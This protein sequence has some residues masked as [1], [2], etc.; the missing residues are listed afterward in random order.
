MT[1]KS[2]MWIWSA[3]VLRGHKNSESIADIQQLRL[4]YL[5]YYNK[6]RFKNQ[7]ASKEPRITWIEGKKFSTYLTFSVTYSAA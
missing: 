1:L 7:F 3:K 2:Q 6:K 5:L 4:Y